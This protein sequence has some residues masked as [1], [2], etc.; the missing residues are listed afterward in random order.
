MSLVSG[1]CKLE[2]SGCTPS[3]QTVFTDFR[4]TCTVDLKAKVG[5]TR[6]PDLVRALQYTGAKISGLSIGTDDNRTERS[7][8]GDVEEVD[9]TAKQPA[10]PDLLHRNPHSAIAKWAMSH[11][12]HFSNDSFKQA[13]FLRQILDN[14]DNATTLDQIKKSQKWYSLEDITLPPTSYTSMTY[15]PKGENQMLNTGSQTMEF[16]EHGN[17]TLRDVKMRISGPSEWIPRAKG[18]CDLAE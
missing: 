14:D 8:S 15:D 13:D 18:D 1:R 17:L 6:A 2:H 12:F 5:A 4:F 11:K 9:T 16:V 7:V 10:T 3:N